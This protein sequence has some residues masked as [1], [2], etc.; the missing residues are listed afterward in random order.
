M[1]DPRPTRLLPC[2]RPAWLPWAVRWPLLLLALLDLHHQ[3]GVESTLALHYARHNPYSSD[4]KACRSIR[5]RHGAG[6]PCNCTAPR[7]PGQS[8]RRIESFGN[9]IIRQINV[10]CSRRATPPWPQPCAPWHWRARRTQAAVGRA[11]SAGPR[12]AARRRHCSPV[13]DLRGLLPPVY[14]EPHFSRSK[15][16]WQ[17]MYRDRLAPQNAALGSPIVEAQASPRSRDAHTAPRRRGRSARYP[18]LVAV[19]SSPFAR[20]C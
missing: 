15:A 2:R 1:Q 6:L 14:V 13:A 5:R 19:P 4:L 7:R 20:D 12:Q 10:P 9:N 17:S 16:N 3:G 11:K 18:S 8:H